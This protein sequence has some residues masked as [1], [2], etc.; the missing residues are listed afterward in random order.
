MR[1]PLARAGSIAALCLA[2]HGASAAVWYVDKYSPGPAHDG[3]TWQTAYPTILAA[4]SAAKAGDEVWVGPGTYVEIIVMKPNVSLYG[5]FIGLELFR[6][7]RV[8]LQGIT[9]LAITGTGS[10]PIVSATNSTITESTVIDGFTFAGTATGTSGGVAITC[11]YASPTISH[12]AFIGMVS[13]N[14]PLIYCSNDRAA[15]KDN[16]IAQCVTGLARIYPAISLGAATGVVANNTIA[17]NG[18]YAIGGSSSALIANNIVA[19]NLAAFTIAAYVKPPTYRNN[20]LYDNATLPQ[21]S[22]ADPSGTN[23]NFTAD[24]KFAIWEYGNLHLAADSPCRDAGDDS[25]VAADDMDM[26]SQPRIQGAHVDIGADESDGRTW[27]FSPRI[28]RVSLSGNDAND[29]STWALA[30]KTIQAGIN[31]ASAYGGD[32]WVQTGSYVVSTASGGTISLKPYCYLYG[33]FAGTETSRDQRDWIAN[34]TFLS[35]SKVAIMTASAGYRASALDGFILTGGTATTAQ[36]SAAGLACVG[37]SPYV[38]NNVFTRCTGAAVQSIYSRPYITN[39]AF[40]NN[41]VGTQLYVVGGASS[42]L[43]VVGNVFSANGAGTSGQSMGAVYA[44]QASTCRIVDNLFEGNATGSSVGASATGGVRCS[45]TV[46]NNTFVNNRGIAIN[47]FGGP[48]ASNIVAFNDVGVSAPSSSAV[49]S[50][51]V[52]GNTANYV[53]TDRTGKSGNV[54][55]YPGFKSLLQGDYRLL[56]SSP[57]VDAGRNAYVSPGDLDL[58]GQPRVQGRSVDMGCY[59][60]SATSIMAHWDDIARALRIVGGLT[61]ANPEDVAL[62]HGT[63]GNPVAVEVQDAS[64]LIKRLTPR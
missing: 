50:N 28:V 4:Y 54:N 47:S 17:G 49:L 22:G 63:T 32:V 20:C 24:P 1:I 2:T 48:I 59:E 53:E 16:V 42:V 29:G 14:G 41:S 10:Q 30:K 39:N 57:C 21:Q 15:F 27:T 35:A 13:S 38:R 3:T 26:D 58:D 5:G 56:D 18:G 34:P 64:A 8:G 31:L 33:G 9:T 51:C 52:Y 6:D 11:S 60:S 36:G 19:H 40:Y 45:G 43:S 46:A 23:G 7:Q 61:I 25:A 12:N 62:I 55:S 37:S 44:D